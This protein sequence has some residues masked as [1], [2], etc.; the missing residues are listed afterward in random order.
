MAGSNNISR[1]CMAAQV[2]P[3][4]DI[5]GTVSGLKGEKGDYS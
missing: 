4:A 2:Q 3:G 5:K 1:A